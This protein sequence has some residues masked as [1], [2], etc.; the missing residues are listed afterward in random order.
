MRLRTRLTLAM[1]LFF[2]VSLFLVEILRYQGVQWEVRDLMLK[3]ARALHSMVMAIRQ[4]YHHQFLD[5][6][7]PLTDET[8]GFLPA[9]ALRRISVDFSNRN[10][11]GISFNNVSE[12]PRNPDNLADDI[13]RQAIAYFRGNPA[14]TERLHVYQLESG[15]TIYH[16]A[17]PIRTEAYCLTCH[18]QSATAPASIRARYDAGYD[19]GVGQLVGIF[20]IKMPGFAIKS[21]TNR[22]FWMNLVDHLTGYLILFIA[23]IAML[24]VFILNR[25]RPLRQAALAVAA[26][27]YRFTLPKGPDDEIGE[28]S[29]AFKDMATTIAERE[30]SL[31]ESEQQKRELSDQ[32]KTL[33]DGIPDILHLLDR[34]FKIVW[35]NKSSADYLGITPDEMVGRT[36]HYKSDI[37]CSNCPSRVA[38][39]TGQTAEEV[40]ST[41]DGRIWGVKAFPLKDEKGTV[42]QVIELASDITEKLKLREEANQSSRLASLGELTAGVAHEINNPNALI[43]LNLPLLQDVFDE[44]LPILDTHFRTNPDGELAGFPYHRMREEIPQVL[45]EVQGGARRIKRIVED[46]K[47]FVRRE[48]TD[49]Q[50]NFLLNEAVQAALRLV[51]NPIHKATDHLVTHYGAD[52]PLLLGNMQRIEQVIINLVVNA[53][54]ALPDRS[55]SITIRTSFDAP[56]SEAVLEVADQGVG[57]APE[58]L[59]RLTESFFTTRREEGGTGLGL[60]VSARIVREHGGTLSFESNPGEGT[61]VILRLPVA[62]EE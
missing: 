45:D 22:L 48:R 10:P 23:L 47:D 61:R 51:A 17:T 35:A 39:S 9:H 20:S 37:P 36:C 15:Q 60:S 28:V 32:L 34:N 44:S 11:S 14:E 19:Y 62:P 26:G 3:E 30:Q 1:L 59:P 33:L 6:G 52:M 4:V 29:T 53:C 12:N 42:H 54:Q 50:E 5:S 43:L 57:I 16:Y 18:G 27:D 7:L 2:A 13:E 46:L 58:N 41:P 8:L 49:R 56:A 24:S 21:M 55:R 31:R 40:I 38:F 25:L